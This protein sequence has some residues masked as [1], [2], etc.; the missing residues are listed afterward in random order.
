M[1]KTSDMV[2][3]VQVAEHGD[4]LWVHASDGSTVGRFD[5]R[6]GIDL[7]TTATEQM[8][9]ASQCLFCTHE[10]PGLAGWD[11]FREE[12]LRHYGLEVPADAIS[13]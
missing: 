12:M 13:F 10:A 6:F 5:K 7:H 3:E 4:T 2:F 11:R 8:A 9:G 1:A